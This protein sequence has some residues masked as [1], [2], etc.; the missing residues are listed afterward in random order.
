MVG[1]LNYRI[2]YLFFGK[3]LTSKFTK[4]NSFYIATTGYGQQAWE[5]LD[6]LINARFLIIYFYAIL[7]AVFSF[8]SQISR[9]YVNFTY[10]PKIYDGR[11]FRKDYKFHLTP[12]SYNKNLGV[13]FSS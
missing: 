1:Q 3:R 4:F 11:V 2:V 5:I 8:E 9:G 6:I 12:G 10:L 7:F 13:S